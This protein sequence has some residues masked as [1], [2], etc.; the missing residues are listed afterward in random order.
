MLVPGLVIFFP[1]ARGGGTVRV[2]GEF[3]ELGSSLVRVIRHSA[4]YPQ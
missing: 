1:M 2:G 3:M 4:A